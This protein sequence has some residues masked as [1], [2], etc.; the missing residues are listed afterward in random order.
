MRT[1]A[2][3]WTI[4]SLALSV[5]VEEIGEVVVERGL[6]M[7]V[8][9]AVAQLERL[10][11][12]RDRPV[13]IALGAIQ[14][15]QVVSAAIRAFGSARSSAQ[16][17]LPSRCSLAADRSPESFARMPSMLCACASAP[18][19]PAASA[20][21]ST[22]PG[23]LKLSTGVLVLWQET[24]GAVARHFGFEG[25]VETNVVCVDSRRQWS[26][27]R[28]IWHSAAIRSGVYTA[29]APARAIA[30]PFRRG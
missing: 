5:V 22:M 7:A 30:R 15:R 16:R 6:S 11:R 21:A 1:V 2:F 20:S 23:R 3:K 14:Q 25:E 12:P 13:D 26:K 18:S 28:N 8:A 9:D 4:A 29:G 19:S 17:K 27:A 10:R 24:L